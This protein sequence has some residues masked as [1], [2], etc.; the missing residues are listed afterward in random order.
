[1]RSVLH[2]NCLAVLQQSKPHQKRERDELHLKAIL[3]IIWNRIYDNSA[4]IQY[5]GYKME[6]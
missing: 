3:Q 2:K 6:S 4:M 5:A 1:M